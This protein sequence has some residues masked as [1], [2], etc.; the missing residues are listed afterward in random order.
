M[1]SFVNNVLNYTA[2]VN[3]FIGGLLYCLLRSVSTDVSAN[4]DDGYG[5]CVSKIPITVVEL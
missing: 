5:Y 1:K 4:V 2:I 3:L